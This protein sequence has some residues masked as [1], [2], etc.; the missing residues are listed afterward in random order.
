MN[1]K[2]AEDGQKN[3]GKFIKTLRERKGLTQSNLARALKTSQ[4]AVA[5]MEKGGQNLTTN[6]L[7][8]ISEVLGQ[9]IFSLS[10]TADFEI[11]GGK[12]LS[13]SI[14]T[15]YSKNGS[16][17]LLCASLLNKGTTRL[18]GI[19]RIEEVYRLIK[20][21]ES[22][23]V[24]VKWTGENSIE[25]IPPKKFNLKKLDTDAAAKTRSA[26]MIIGAL[27]HREKNFS[28]P[29]TGG[30]KMGE[31]TI[32]AHK[33]GLRE[34]H[35]SITTYEH[36]YEITI[37]K[38]GLRT[39]NIVMYEAS[40]TASE[41]LLIA[42]SLIPGT[43]KIEF[44]TSNYQIQEICF[45]LETCGVKIDGI[46]TTTLMIHGI[47]EINK[48]IEYHNSE[49]PIESMMFI[50]AAIVTDSKL[51]I[52]RCPIY[53][54]KVELLKLKYM[55]LKYTVSKEYFSHNK[56]TKLVDITIY[57]SKLKALTDKIHA[58][59]YPGINSDNLPFFVPL[60]S[61]AKGVTMIHDW[62]WE[63]RAI[64]FTELNRLGAKITLVDPHRVF[65]EGGTELKGA[66]IVSPPALR[67][68]MII[69]VA[70]LG[71]KGRSILRNVY[72]INRGFENI[73]ER[74]RSIGAD[75]HV[76]NSI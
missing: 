64:Y 57:P 15:Q 48:T 35:V 60:A 21:L 75:I 43:T 38:Q 22:I 11:V 50:S 55:G 49:D 7:S 53:F 37:H 70:M 25:M 2:K 4:S 76:I 10:D 3:I 26:L 59:P 9:N 32:A 68:A 44:A 1:M 24:S 65:I 56:R 28:F 34:L 5:R 72:T 29:H 30:C 16:V 66:Q 18:H 36:G 45:F 23:G 58:L 14:T 47:Q 6:L 71:A 52:K 27:I 63:S 54:L 39:N 61:K 62:M 73:A 41:N 13:G 42:A 51:M 31:R 74:L 40:D 12:K 17:G 20:V 33:Y 69:L 8:N 67:P 46:G 19:S